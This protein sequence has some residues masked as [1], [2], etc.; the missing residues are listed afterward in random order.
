[1]KTHPQQPHAAGHDVRWYVAQT[2]PGVEGRAI[3]H[4][5]RQGFAVFCPRYRKIIRHARKHT[6]AL[7][8]LFPGYL[9]LRLDAL[10]DRWRS[11]NGTR[12]VARLLTQGDIPS[13]VPR[14]IVEA[15]QNHTGMDG[16][17]DWMPSLNVGQSVRVEEGPFVDFVGTLE[18]LDGVGRAC[19]LLNLL[20][21]SVSVTMHCEALTPAA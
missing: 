13:P 7:L 1:M 10:C 19:V 4:L 11:V 17:M 14:G 20:G 5:E 9:F 18:R 6:N 8:P 3:A 21:R 15:L 12:G 16:A 2:Q